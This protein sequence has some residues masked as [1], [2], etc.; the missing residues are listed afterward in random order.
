MGH[1]S[2]LASMEVTIAGRE[3]GCRYNKRHR[4]VKGEKRLTVKVDGDDHN[5]CLACAKTFIASSS[6]R[7]AA[8]RAEVDGLLPG[9]T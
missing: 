6:E 4:I 3:H 9:A 8:L 1:K 2:L 7:L 5:Y